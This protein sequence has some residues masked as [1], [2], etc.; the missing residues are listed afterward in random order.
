MKPRLE[1]A[2][3][4]LEDQRIWIH[5]TARFRCSPLSVLWLSIDRR[6]A[7]L[8]WQ[9]ASEFADFRAWQRAYPGVWHA[10]CAFQGMRVPEDLYA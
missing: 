6:D 4:T 1:T 9:L 7:D 3:L 5:V 2:I 8:M 10:A